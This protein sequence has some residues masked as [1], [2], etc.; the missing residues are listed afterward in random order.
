EHTNYNLG[1]LGKKSFLRTYKSTS[2]FELIENPELH[3]KDHE[4]YDKNIAF[5]GALQNYTRNEIA[6]LITDI[7]AHFNKNV[8][9]K[10]N[11]LVVGNLENLERTKGYTKS[12]KIKKAESLSLEGLPIEILS[13]LDFIKLL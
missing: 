3:N 9:R 4:F 10:T 8:L 12:S 13:E 11:I 7:G 2:N 1:I 5:T 6:Q